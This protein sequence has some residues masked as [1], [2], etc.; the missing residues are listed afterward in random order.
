MSKLCELCPVYGLSGKPAC[1]FLLEARQVWS[2]IDRLKTR[3]KYH[4]TAYVTNTTWQPTSQTLVNDVTSLP[5][6]FLQQKTCLNLTNFWTGQNIF[7]YRYKLIIHWMRIDTFRMS[8]NI[9]NFVKFNIDY[10]PRFFIAIIKIMLIC[11]FLQGTYHI[12]TQP[13]W[14]TGKFWSWWMLSPYFH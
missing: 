11:T 8:Y 7:Q 12:V 10:F 2:Y 9:T 14:Q 6:C 4:V 3:H 1:D 13:D 5:D